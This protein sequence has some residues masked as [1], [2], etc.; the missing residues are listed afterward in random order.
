MPGAIPLIE[1]PVTFDIQLYTTLQET[2]E[3]LATGNKKMEKHNHII[4]TFVTSFFLP[5]TV[6][7][8]LFHVTL[9]FC[10]IDSQLV[11]A[12]LVHSVVDTIVVYYDEDDWQIVSGVTERL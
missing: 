12:L 9:P 8:H 6:H 1:I 11:P 2:I 10:R 4:M 3:G 5:P 7:S